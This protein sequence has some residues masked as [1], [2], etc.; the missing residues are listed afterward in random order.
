MLGLGEEFVVV[1][2]AFMAECVRVELVHVVWNE[3]RWVRWCWMREDVVI[4]A[5][6]RPFRR[7]DEGDLRVLSQILM[8]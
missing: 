6:V 1:R 5:E 8:G 3:E 7:K 4:E 2:I